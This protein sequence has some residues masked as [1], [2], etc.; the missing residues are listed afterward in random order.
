M[1]YTLTLNPA[2]DYVAHVKDFSVGTIQR[3]KNEQYFYGGKGIN[4]SSILSVL[5]IK[6]VA[7]GFLAGFTGV[8]IKQGLTDKGIENDF[9]F[10][11]NGFTRI[12]V[13]IR[14]NDETDINGQG[15][16]VDNESLDELLSKINE[17]KSGDTLVLAGSIPPSLPQNMY[18][19]IMDRLGDKDI[20]F[21]VDATGQL[22][23]SSLKYNPFMI[24]PNKE[25]L[26]DLFDVQIGSNEDLVKYASKLQEMGAKNVL[27][28]LGGDGAMLLDENG[29]TH[30]MEAFKGKIVNTVGAGDSMVAGFIAGYEKTNDYAYALKLGSASGSAT[31]F[32]E[33]LADSV[34]INNLLEK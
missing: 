29:Q 28:S 17:L 12:N 30:Y 25:E 31:A 1:I 34:T 3:S 33:G 18:E 10:L 11:K 27:V 8:A 24:K 21:V 16:D 26:E 19:Q 20:R 14:S 5:G 4:V 7:L 9:V 23:L 6:S 22:L 32:S 2:L 15:P 13:K